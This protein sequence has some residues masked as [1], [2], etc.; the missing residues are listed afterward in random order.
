[1]GERRRGSEPKLKENEV[2]ENNVT[3]GECDR[4]KEIKENLHCHKSRCETYVYHIYF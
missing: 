3:C 4:E 2:E 1:M